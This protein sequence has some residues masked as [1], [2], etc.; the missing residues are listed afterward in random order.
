MTIMEALQWANNKLKKAELDSPML[1]A[2]ILLASVLNVPK[3]WL[4]G[5]FTE[6]LKSHHEEKF[7]VLLDRRMKHEPV[8]YLTGKKNF[9]GREFAVS[10]A[11]L[12]P[13]PATE[14]MIEHVL[15]QFETCDRDL[16]MFADIGTGSGAIAVTLASETQSPV[17]AIDIEA[18]ALA[19]AKENAKRHEATEHI[20]FQHGSY[21]EPVVKLFETIHASGNP[22]VSSV[23]PFRDLI[24]CA[25]LPYLTT[26]QMDTLEADV[27]FEP[28]RALVAGADGLDAYWELFRQLKTHRELLPRKITVYIEIDPDQVNRSLTLIQHNFPEAVLRIEKDL[29]ENDRIIIAEI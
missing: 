19:M 11:V 4:F 2:E 24:I 3:S 16:V 5:H 28:V 20:D 21:L 7:L 15:H 29:Q 9:Y 17:L 8:A 6:E 13:R 10:P 12:I 1:D 26:N 23:Y 22:N 18:A 25:N 14:T 27:R